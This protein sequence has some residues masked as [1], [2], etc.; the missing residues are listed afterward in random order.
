MQKMSRGLYFPVFA[1]SGSRTPLALQRDTPLAGC[2]LMSVNAFQGRPRIPGFETDESARKAIEAVRGEP[3]AYDIGGTRV[4]D[5]QRVPE[6]LDVAFVHH[7]AASDIA[8]DIGTCVCDECVFVHGMVVVVRS[9]S[10]EPGLEA[11]EFARRLDGLL[12]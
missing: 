7:C 3:L 6:E 12:Q 8:R 2:H 10:M 11:P 1:A 5:V 4:Y 9:W